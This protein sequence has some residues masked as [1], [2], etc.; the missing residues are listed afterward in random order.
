MS[1]EKNISYESFVKE[2]ANNERIHYNANKDTVK[3][4]AFVWGREG[5]MVPMAECIQ[6][7]H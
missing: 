5:Q 2:L 3:I 1:E 4:K 6:T 7:V